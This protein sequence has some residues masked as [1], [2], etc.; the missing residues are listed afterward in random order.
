MEDFK[1]LWDQLHCKHEYV[2][3]SWGWVPGYFGNRPT[4]VEAKMR[5]KLCG[6]IHYIYPERDGAVELGITSNLEKMK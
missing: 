4:S 6:K 3:E 1:R 5:C 2:L